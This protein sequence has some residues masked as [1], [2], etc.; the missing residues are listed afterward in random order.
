MKMEV[1]SEHCFMLPYLYPICLQYI[2]WWNSANL[3][4]LILKT[5]V[6]KIS[7]MRYTNHHYCYTSGNPKNGNIKKKC[8]EIIYSLIEVG[9]GEKFKS[10]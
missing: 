1:S 8:T 4:L 10:S 3:D 5:E 9:V 7:S 2:A 6:P